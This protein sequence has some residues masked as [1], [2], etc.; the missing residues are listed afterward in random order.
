[1]WGCPPALP[2][3]AGA[4]AGGGGRAGSPGSPA[5]AGLFRVK[6]AEIDYFLIKPK[7]LSPRLLIPLSSEVFGNGG[8]PAPLSPQ[9]TGIFRAR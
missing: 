2:A 7:V 1:M 3:R 5:G 4:A 8:P 6:K 9:Y